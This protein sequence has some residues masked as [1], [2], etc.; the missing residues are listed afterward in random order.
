MLIIAAP[1]VLSHVSKI[2]RCCEEKQIIR[3]HLFAKIL[4]ASTVSGH[5]LNVSPM[6]FQYKKENNA[7][8]NLYKRE[9]CFKSE[10][11]RK[12]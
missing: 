3:H 6:R 1:H 5:C 4:G 10:G 12:T 2:N 7:A 8:M 11:V 9:V